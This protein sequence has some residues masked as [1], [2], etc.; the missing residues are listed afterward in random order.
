MTLSRPGFR[1]KK[2]R[3]VGIKPTGRLF[4]FLVILFPDME[5]FLLTGV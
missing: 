5:V 1:D 2:S 3:P 4:V